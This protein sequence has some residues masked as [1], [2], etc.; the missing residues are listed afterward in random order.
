MTDPSAA[1]TAQRRP[2][3]K[4]SHAAAGARWLAAGVSAAATLGMAGA[5][6][7]AGAEDVVTSAPEKVTIIVS[8]ATPV[9]ASTWEAVAPEAPGVDPAQTA[10]AQATYQIVAAAEPA[11]TTSGGS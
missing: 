1:V 4:K 2:A 11:D 3:K 8:R 6:S 9:P 10:P 7:A 5:M